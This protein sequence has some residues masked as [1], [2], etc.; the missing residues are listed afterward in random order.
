[1]FGLSSLTSMLIG[2][3]A[4][5]LVAGGTGAYAGYRWEYGALEH[6]KRIVDEKDLKQA[7]DILQGYEANVTT[8]N[9]AAREFLAGQNDFGVKLD[10]I[11]KDL[12]NVQTQK[13]LPVNCK[14][15]PGRVRDLNAAIQA[16][17]TRISR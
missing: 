7:N 1:M 8:I 4:I 10:E 14:P 17:N 15:D 5:A 9:N 2:A 6:E 16:T 11:G 3:A 12:H 13:P